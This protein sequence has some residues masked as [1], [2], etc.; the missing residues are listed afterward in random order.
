MAERKAREISDTVESLTRELRNEKQV[1]RTAIN[2]ARRAGK[3]SAAIKRAIETLG[4]KV[5]FSGIG[6]YTVAI[7]SNPAEFT[8]SFMHPPSKRGDE[9][10]DTSVSITVMGDDDD[11]SGNP[12]SSVCEML[13]PLRTRDGGC[14]WPDAG[15]AQFG[16]QFVGLKANFDA[17]DRL[18]I[19]DSY[20]Q[21]Q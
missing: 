11:V 1:T 10:S 5:Q 15:C 7:E 19:N 8:Q 17:F 4:C 16:S 12:I 6:D 9:K 18:S 20:F 3:E 14:R 21:S 2:A 13:C